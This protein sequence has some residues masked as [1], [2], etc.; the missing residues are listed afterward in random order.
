MFAGSTAI[1]LLRRPMRTALCDIAKR[2][3]RFFRLR[4]SRTASAN[5]RGT[6]QIRHS[7]R[8]QAR[9]YRRHALETGD[10]G[11]S[12]ESGDELEQ[13]AV[14]DAEDGR[15]RH[16]DGR[17]SLSEHGRRARNGRSCDRPL[18]FGTTI[19]RAA[20]ADGCVVMSS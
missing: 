10:D 14:R 7:E 12:V 13:H 9:V 6:R 4:K 19:Q 18:A 17:P 3:G 15:E 11:R 1:G 16:Q 8:P 5:L 20:F 2:S